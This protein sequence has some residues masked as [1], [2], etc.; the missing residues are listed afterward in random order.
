MGRLPKYWRHSLVRNDKPQQ[1]LLPETV[2]A[3]QIGIGNSRRKYISR[4]EGFYQPERRRAGLG[5]PPTT[6]EAA[7]AASQSSTPTACFPRGS[8]A[9]SP[10]RN[11]RPRTPAP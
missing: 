8:R 4:A 6:V 1:V 5:R 11:T 7:A 10:A 9:F 3:M 2:L